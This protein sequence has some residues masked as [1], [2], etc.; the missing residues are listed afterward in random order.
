MGMDIVE[1]VEVGV[2]WSFARGDV[3][4]LQIDDT[5]TGLLVLKYSR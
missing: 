4:F 5:D 2:G 1:M 3:S